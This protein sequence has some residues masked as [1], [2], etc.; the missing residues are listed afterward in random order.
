MI[1][2]SIDVGIKNLAYCLLNYDDDGIYKIE[3]WNVI[4]LCA[5]NEAPKIICNSLQKNKKQC[6]NQA[7]YQREVK[8]YCKKHTKKSGFKIPTQELNSI[9]MKRY[10]KKKL[11][12]IQNKYDIPFEFDKT[13]KDTHKTQLFKKLMNEINTTFLSTIKS[14]RNNAN[15]FKLAQLGINMKK[16]FNTQLDYKVIDTIAIENQI[17]PLALRM[18]SLQGMI[19]QHFIENDITEIFE[20][21]SGNKLKDFI[22]KKKTT[23][24]ERKKIGI[25]ITR[26]IIEDKA[27]LNIWLD[28]FNKS[29]KKDDLADCF[30]QGIWFIKNKKK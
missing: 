27:H 15:D 12:Y 30:L 3:K 1:L 28:E 16:I 20:V 26:K 19:I 24:A 18:K 6:K 13:L 21:S 7:K 8:Y 23:Y 29:K 5:D 10:T 11:E 25:D 9:K 2:L 14:T 17:G 4:N 22:E